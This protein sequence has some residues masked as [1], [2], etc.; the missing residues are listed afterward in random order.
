[1]YVSGPRDN[2]GAIGGG[3]FSI[4][5]HVLDILDWGFEKNDVKTH[6]GMTKNQ[7]K[8]QNPNCLLQSSPTMHS[9]ITTVRNIFIDIHT[10]VNRSLLPMHVP[11]PTLRQQ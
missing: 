5:L 4:Y 9:G 10:G 7:A 6:N 2:R 1:M 11:S 8:K 3:T